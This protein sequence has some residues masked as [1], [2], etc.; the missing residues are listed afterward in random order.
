MKKANEDLKRQFII[1]LVIMI[2]IS[3][4]IFVISS[5]VELDKRFIYNNLLTLSLSFLSVIG[6]SILIKTIKNKNQ[7]TN[8]L[9]FLSLLIA[10]VFWFAG[11][12]SYSYL[13]IVE[14]EDLPFPGP[15]E[16]FFFSGYFF[17]IYYLYQNFK[18]WSRNKTIKK[19]YVIFSFSLTVFLISIILYITIQEEIN[20]IDVFL[21]DLSYYVLDGIILFPAISILLSVLK[22]DPI[23]IHQILISL[24][25]VSAVSGDFGYLYLATTTDEEIAAKYEWVWVMLYSYD[26]LFVAFAGLWYSRII[27]ISHGH[28]NR[29]MEDNKNRFQSLWHLASDSEHEN[30]MDKSEIKDYESEDENPQYFNDDYEI[31][32]YLGKEIRTV[33]ELAILYSSQNIKSEDLS[34]NLFHLLIKLFNYNKTI[35]TRILLKNKINADFDYLSKK[36]KNNPNI[37]IRPSNNSTL[38]TQLSSF[39]II[40]LDKNRFFNITINNSSKLYCIFFN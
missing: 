14:G 22:R 29:V 36:F 34:H 25:I 5:F 40:I 10:M 27:T 30:T 13:Q 38:K 32:K 2:S 9:E 16:I 6:L 28:I 35:K 12:A 19:S 21:T 15:P 26:Y 23:S 31:S 4:I 33:K 11:E 3:S 17:L 8:V 18:F 7:P 37:E 1:L 39:M 20:E 24:F